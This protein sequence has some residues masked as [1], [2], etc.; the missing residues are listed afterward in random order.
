[1]CLVHT[2]RCIVVIGMYVGGRRHF[3]CLG[4]HCI[5]RHYKAFAGSIL[6]ICFDWEILNLVRKYLV[7]VL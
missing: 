7:K 1:M 4:L 2:C 5:Y 6:Y 3:V